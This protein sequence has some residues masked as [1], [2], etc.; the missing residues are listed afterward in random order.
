MNRDRAADSDLAI[1]TDSELDEIEARAVARIEIEA[2][3]QSETVLAALID[4]VR[5]DIPH[6]I[7]EIRRLRTEN[8]RL[9]TTGGQAGIGTPIP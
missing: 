8:D 1:L 7:A 5:K 4:S 2:I 3:P 6:L 9:R